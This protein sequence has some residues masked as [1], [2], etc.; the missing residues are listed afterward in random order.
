MIELPVTFLLFGCL[1]LR[2]LVLAGFG[3]LYFW[4]TATSV[5]CLFIYSLP[6]N[7]FYWVLF[8][9]YGTLRDRTKLVINLHSWKMIYLKIIALFLSSFWCT[10]FLFLSLR[11]NI[12]SGG[13]KIIR[14]LLFEFVLRVF[15]AEDFGIRIDEKR[16]FFNMLLLFLRR[17]QQKSQWINL[18]FT[19]D[20][21]KESFKICSLWFLRKGS[22]S[23]AV[24]AHKHVSLSIHSEVF[25]HE[26][27]S[28]KVVEVFVL[29]KVIIF[30]WNAFDCLN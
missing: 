8:S 13:E 25:T 22:L 21:C 17:L 24:I 9:F 16:N 23:S 5:I 28:R 6:S 4:F 12:S 1:H 2:V 19:R 14:F 3:F 11:C 20:W 18:R 15:F 7:I 29:P 26:V 10:T 30:V 27:V